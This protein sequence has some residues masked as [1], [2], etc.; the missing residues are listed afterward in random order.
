VF[1]SPDSGILKVK[2]TSAPSRKS[3]QSRVLRRVQTM[4]EETRPF[5]ELE[6]TW[7]TPEWRWAQCSDVSGGGSWQPPVFAG[8]EERMKVVGWACSLEKNPD[9]WD[10]KIAFKENP[11]KRRRK[12]QVDVRTVQTVAPVLKRHR[13][14]DVPDDDEDVNVPA[15]R[16]VAE[17]TEDEFAVLSPEELASRGK[18]LLERKS[19]IKHFHR[20]GIQCELCVITRQLRKLSYVQGL[21]ET[22][23]SCSKKDV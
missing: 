21:Q 4:T 2:A 13:S 22:A 18:I 6:D 20:R 23:W 17:L 5:A 1:V 10:S 8:G 11:N 9:V 12:K 14:S 7:L 3:R 15:P 19:Q 16:V